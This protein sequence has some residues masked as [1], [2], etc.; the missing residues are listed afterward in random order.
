LGA[1][2]DSRNNVVES[3]ENNNSLPGGK[4]VVAK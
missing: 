2:A 3:N 1:I 4:I